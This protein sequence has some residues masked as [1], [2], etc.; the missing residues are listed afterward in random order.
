[1]PIEPGKSCSGM[2]IFKLA[3]PSVI[4]IVIHTMPYQKPLIMTSAYF[5][6]SPSRDLI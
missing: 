4:M 1:M 3:Y 2:M 6:L 5:C